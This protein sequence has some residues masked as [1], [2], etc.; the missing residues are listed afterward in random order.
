MNPTEAD[1]TTAIGEF[2]REKQAWSYTEIIRRT[3]GLMFRTVI[4]RDAYD[5]QSYATLYK[6][7]DDRGW[8][9]F[10]SLPTRT[11]DYMRAF[12]NA[13]EVE[14]E[15]KDYYSLYIKTAHQLTLICQR[16][17]PIGAN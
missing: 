15:H 14:M 11:G 6:W 10:Y 1:S 3:D 8:L 9:A 17:F 4:Y 16:F 13:T 2:S 12:Y 7:S 5:D